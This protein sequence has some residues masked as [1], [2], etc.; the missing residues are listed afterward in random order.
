MTPI[1][2]T[3]MTTTTDY[4]AVMVRRARGAQ[5]VQICNVLCKDRHSA[6]RAAKAHGFHIPRHAYAVRIGRSGYYQALKRAGF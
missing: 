2:P 3:D 1:P 5:P 6:L 4:Y